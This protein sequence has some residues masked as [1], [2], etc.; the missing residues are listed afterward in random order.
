MVLSFKFNS[1]SYFCCYI[2]FVCRFRLYFQNL[3]LVLNFN[4]FCKTLRFLFLFPLFSF[5]YSFF[6]QRC[7]TSLISYK[8]YTDISFFTP[9]WINTSLKNLNLLICIVYMCFGEKKNRK[10]GMVSRGSLSVKWHL[11]RGL[12]TMKDSDL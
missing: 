10:T 6:L 1:Y 8:L 7:R 12:N 3:I 2:Y 5:I 9:L 11:N 4:H